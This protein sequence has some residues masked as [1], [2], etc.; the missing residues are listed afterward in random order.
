MSFNF[1]TILVFIGL[2]I[3]GVEYWL[4]SKQK[5]KWFY[6]L[7]ISGAFVAMTV[8]T[9]LFIRHN[10]QWAMILFNVLL[11]WKVICYTRGIKSLQNEERE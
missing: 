2:A 8:N 3:A 7:S 1:L 9:T 11:V 4:A 6:I 10:D 5:M